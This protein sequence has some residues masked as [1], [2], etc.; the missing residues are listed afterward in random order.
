MNNTKEFTV[1]DAM[2]IQ[3]QQLL[4]W[5]SVLKPEKY[6]LLLEYIIEA[7]VGVTEGR[8]IF[9]GN[10]IDMFVHNNL[11]DKVRVTF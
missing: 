7:N 2:K 9:R 8:M 3:N 11:M 10:S 4:Q 1:A 5:K 6:I